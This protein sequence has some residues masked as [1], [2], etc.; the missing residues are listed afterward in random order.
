MAILTVQKRKEMF[1]TRRSNRPCLLIS[2]PRICGRLLA[3]DR[4]LNLY[5][6]AR[7]LPD[8]KIRYA[9]QRRNRQQQTQKAVF[10]R[11]RDVRGLSR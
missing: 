7:R 2:R 3:L 10:S 6:A 1:A 4:A 5:G 11:K 9:D 8:P